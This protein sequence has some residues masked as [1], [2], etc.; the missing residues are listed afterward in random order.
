MTSRLIRRLFPLLAA[1]LLAP[2][3]ACAQSA[4]APVAGEDYEVIEAGQP[5]RPLAGKVEVVEVFSYSCPHCAA[6]D[7]SI[8]AWAAKLPKDVRFN[9]V[10]AAFDANDQFSRGFFAAEQAGVLRQTHS[11]LFR[12]IHD[13]ESVP[14]R[15]P[16]VAELATFYAAHGLPAAKF[17]AAVATPAMD[18]KMA[19]ARAFLVAAGIT[20]T[21]S[22]IV[23]GKYRIS[24]KS[25]EDTLRIADQLIAKE[26]AARR[27]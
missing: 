19:S 5:W 2:L 15:N 21:P 20:G 3:S 1:L 9:Y 23:D 12:A 17:R 6:F 11:A 8:E 13:E 24:G 18:A 16:S 14:M 4:G 22:L 7:P 10:P 27:K 25:H 26:R